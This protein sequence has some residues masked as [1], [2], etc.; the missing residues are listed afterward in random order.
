MFIVVV[1]VVVIGVRIDCGVD[2]A[3]WLHC[4][5]SEVAA[6]DC[7]A[8]GDDN[9]VELLMNGMGYNQQQQI[10]CAFIGIL[11]VTIELH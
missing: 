2:T 5:E 10:H 11:Q 9:C 8:A 3:L 7:S 6:V 4:E 1:V